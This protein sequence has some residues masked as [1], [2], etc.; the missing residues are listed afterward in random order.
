[1]T[2]PRP[3]SPDGHQHL[4]QFYGTDALALARCVGRYL[5][6]GLKQGQGVVAIATPEHSRAITRELKRLGA[7]LE[8]A[9]HSGRIV[10]LDA[11]RT[12]SRFLVEGW[13]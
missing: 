6:D 9:A 4:V 7:D 1:M 10:L 3:V 8:A 13:P 12:L 5:W 11:G 2:A